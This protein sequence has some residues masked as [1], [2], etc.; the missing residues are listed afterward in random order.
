MMTILFL[1]QTFAVWPNSRL[2]TPMVPG[3]QTSCVMSTSAFTQM[4]SPAWTLALPAARARIFSVNVIRT[5]IS[6]CTARHQ[7]NKSKNAVDIRAVFAMIGGQLMKTDLTNWILT[8]VLS[9]LAVAGA[10][11][12]VRTVMQT[13]EWRTI[14]TQAT[15]QNSFI[16]QSQVLLNDVAAYNQK[17]PSPELTKL[18]QALQARP[19]AH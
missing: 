3:P 10:V 1:S 5:K 4:L 13:H 11:L 6:R 12:V 8:V 15:G 19:A 9:V 7:L 14:S 16:A 2:N 17:N 18:L